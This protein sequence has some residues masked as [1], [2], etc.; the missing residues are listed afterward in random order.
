MRKSDATG[1][2]R[3]RLVR[4]LLICCALCVAA[5]R[6]GDAS[7]QSRRPSAAPPPVAAAPPPALKRKATRREVRRFGYGNTLTLYGAPDGSITVEGWPRAEIEIV[8][9]IE[10]QADTEEELARLAAVN[11][12]V[13]D[14][15]A[16]HFRLVTTGTHDRKFMQKAAKTNPAAKNFPKHLLA[17]PWRIDYRIRVPAS[18]DLDVFAGRGALVIEGVRGA[19]Q[20]NA[21]ESR[22]VLTLAGGDVSATVVGGSL[23]LRV[24]VQSWGG[25]GATV[26]MAAGELTVA[27]PAGFNGEVSATILRTG[28]IEGADAVF[29]GAEGGNP[30]GRSLRVRSGGGGAPLAFEV[31]DGVIRFERLGV[32]PPP[33]Q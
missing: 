10:W 20:L 9:D 4:A 14:E 33:P 32:A 7:A 21:G 19:L 15:D 12:F 6:A 30:T 18:V 23:L 11:G 31:V 22:S 13:L 2:A 5:A 26:K 27:L 1:F 8:A 25:R 17:M 24:P 16:T 29:A 28:R 3:L